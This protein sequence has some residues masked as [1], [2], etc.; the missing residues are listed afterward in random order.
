MTRRAERFLRFALSHV[1][2][3]LEMDILPKKAKGAA[4]R[5]SPLS[6][7]LFSVF[8]V[9]CSQ[10]HRCP[11]GHVTTKKTASFVLDLVWPASIASSTAAVVAS[12]G[13]SNGSS[14]ASLNTS[15]NISSNATSTISSNASSTTSLNTSLNTSTTSTTSLNTSTTSTTSLNTST[16]SLNTPSTSS[17]NSSTSSNTSSNTPSSTPSST[18]SNTSSNNSSIPSS[19]PSTTT[20]TPSSP[21]SF[22]QVLERSLG[23]ESRVSNWCE[24]CR[25]D[26]EGVSDRSVASLPQYILVM[27]GEPS[28]DTTRVNSFL[29]LSVAVD[30]EPALLPPQL[31]HAAPDARRDLPRDGGTRGK[32]YEIHHSKRAVAGHRRRLRQ[33]RLL[34]PPPP[35]HARGHRTRLV[36]LQRLRHHT[37]LPRQRAR[38]HRRVEIPHLSRLPLRR[39]PRGL[40]RTSTLGAHA[41]TA[42]TLLLPIVAGGSGRTADLRAPARG[43][44]ARKGRTHLHRLR[45]HRPRLRTGALASPLSPRRISRP[46][47]TASC[48]RRPICSWAASPVSRATSPSS[49]TITFSARTPSPTTSRASADSS[50]R[51]SSSGSANTSSCR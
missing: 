21:L 48:G 16:T 39:L 43:Q 27:I 4:G 33:R 14:N 41:A 30:A 11:Q 2:S 28:T 26:E 9:A 8:G 42:T 12:N 1:M 6:Q 46:T 18:P 44:T 37:H 5:R 38:L 7:L 20:S 29:S 10:S 17:N 24:V 51:T 32:R 49:S 15:L 31:H 36:L 47:A 50:T 25:R 45:V 22:E 34:P 40:H 3:E 35:R 19:T 13:S 23:G